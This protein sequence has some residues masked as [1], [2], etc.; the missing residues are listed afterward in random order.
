MLSK[1]IPSKYVFLACKYHVEDK[2]PIEMLQLRFHQWILYIRNKGKE[3]F[4]VNTLTYERFDQ[5][6]L[7]AIREALKPNPIYDDGTV[8]FGEFKTKEDALLYPLYNKWCTSESSSKYNEY[9]NKG[10]RLFIIENN[11]LDY[12]LKRVC[13]AIGHGNVEYWNTDGFQLLENLVNDVENSEHQLYQKTLPKPVVEYL[14]DIAANQTEG[15]V[16]NELN[17]NRKMTMRRRIRLTEGDLRRV[18]NKGVK[19]ALNEIGHNNKYG[20][21]WYNPATWKSKSDKWY[22]DRR[23]SED[24]DLRVGHYMDILCGIHQT[25]INTLTQY[26]VIMSEYGFN[27]SSDF[28][29]FPED[30]L[31]KV[32]ETCHCAAELKKEAINMYHIARKYNTTTYEGNTSSLYSKFYL[33][34][35]EPNRIP[36][37]KDL[38][39]GSYQ[40]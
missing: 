1:G 21:K 8:F 27:S 7:E 2:I 20:E 36:T 31:Q 29:E 33:G 13:A 35:D 11:Q 26:F 40:S 15:H 24:Q 18:V 32:R 6:V 19:R 17:C 14:Y 9:T 28:S 16:N 5:I 25:L 3:N 37:L 12:P 4:D 10:Y 38:D 39:K 30:V 22:M 23:N 34:S